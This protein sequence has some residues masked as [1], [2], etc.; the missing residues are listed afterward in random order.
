M[1][2]GLRDA[3]E[4]GFSLVEALVALFLFGTAAVGLMQLQSQSLRLLLDAETRSLAGLVAQNRL[5]ETMASQAA[6]TEGTIEGQTIL[7]RR[8]WRWRVT[9]ERTEDRASL[10]LTVVVF[11]PDSDEIAAEVAAFTPAPEAAP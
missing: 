1:S 8:D 5:V 6:P 9:T 7:A 2:S 3:D 4:A 11:A 10:Q